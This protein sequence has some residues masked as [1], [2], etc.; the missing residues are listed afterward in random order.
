MRD[1]AVS[2]NSMA[3]RL[4]S[5]RR[6]AARVRRHRVA[7]A[8]HP[9]HRARH[10]G[11]SSST[12][13]SSRPTRARHVDAAMDE[14]DRLHRMIEGLLALSRAEDTRRRAGRGRSGGDG[15]RA[16]RALGAAR[17]GGRRDTARPRT[18][19]GSVLAVGGA[20]EQIIDNLV[21]N[22][23]DVSP[24]GSMLRLSVVRVRRWVRAARR[25]RRARPVAGRAAA[26][27]FDRFW[28]GK[29]AAPG[30]SG[31][32]SRS[33]VSSPPR[34]AVMPSCARRRRVASTRWVLFRAP[35]RRS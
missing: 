20:T 28:R 4:Q 3:A 21:D 35:S 1:L 23:L 8:A 10:R 29:R 7:P 33:C 6:A 32:G 26:A 2:F 5:A 25:R 24:P 9:D 13:T 14:T 15:P 16:R 30:G 27:S 18:A 17:V 22:A 19:R 11:S 12:P 31:S 34:P